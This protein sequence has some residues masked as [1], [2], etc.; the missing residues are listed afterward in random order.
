MEWG[1][2]FRLSASISNALICH[3]KDDKTMESFAGRRDWSNWKI[4][5]SKSKGSVAV[6]RLLQQ[7]EHWS[8]VEG[9]SARMIAGGDWAAEG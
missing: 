9:T 6:P 1:V 2:A 5:Q 4:L 7:G 3:Y 8:F